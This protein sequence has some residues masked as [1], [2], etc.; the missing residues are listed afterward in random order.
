MTDKRTGGPYC[1]YCRNATADKAAHPE[2]F[3]IS[4]HVQRCTARGCPDCGH[5]KERHNA[6][7]SILGGPLM[8]Q[9]G[10]CHG[11]CWESANTPF[12]GLVLSD[13]ARRLHGPQA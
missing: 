8:A 6:V 5:P 4:T 10:T 3:D 11:V 7:A 2:T 12:V 1:A 9:C 13:I